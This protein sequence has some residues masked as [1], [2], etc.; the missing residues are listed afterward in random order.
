MK[1]V[2]QSAI[3][4]VTL[5]SSAA[6]AQ[7]TLLQEITESGE[8]RACFDAGYMPFEMK[9]K[10]G[11]FIGFDIDL[12]KNK[13]FIVKGVRADD[14]NLDMNKIIEFLLMEG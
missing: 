2:I 10:N 1:R 7:Q 8:L 5:L 13:D 3:A 9:A 4:A 12:A 14:F 6:F 11:Q